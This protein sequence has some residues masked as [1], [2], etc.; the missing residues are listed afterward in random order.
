[1]TQPP[2]LM[3]SAPG[4]G[5]CRH[6]LWQRGADLHWCEVAANRLHAAEAEQEPA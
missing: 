3:R 1:M 2:L 6:V 5:T 4:C